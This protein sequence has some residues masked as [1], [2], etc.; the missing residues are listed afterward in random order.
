MRTCIVCG[1]TDDLACSTEDLVGAC[2]WT[3]TIGRDRGVC[4]ACPEPLPS[5]QLTPTQRAARAKHAARIRRIR[6]QVDYSIK[7]LHA[8]SDSYERAREASREFERSLERYR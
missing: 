1:C 7:R 8:E 6:N 5:R 4:S 2:S 3:R